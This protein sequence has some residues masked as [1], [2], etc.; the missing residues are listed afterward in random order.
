M[1][2][3]EEIK[4][5]ALCRMTPD[6]KAESL[7]GKFPGLFPCP[8]LTIIYCPYLLPPLFTGDYYFICIFH[9]YLVHVP[10]FLK[11]L[12]FTFFHRCGDKP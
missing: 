12:E 1:N 6:T 7:F 11:L 10:G 5:R 4:E 8:L 3:L 2:V 9:P